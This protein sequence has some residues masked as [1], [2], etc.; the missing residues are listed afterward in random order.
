MCALALL[1]P[2]LPV[3]FH[4]QVG[5]Y[6]FSLAITSSRRFFESIF[7]LLMRKEDPGFVEIR[8]SSGQWSEYDEI[9]PI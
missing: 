1:V 9:S 4:L 6:S 5:V 3:P 2:L 7:S 8:R